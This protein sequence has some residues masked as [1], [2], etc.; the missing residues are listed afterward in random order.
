MERIEEQLGML[1]LTV[2]DKVTGFTGIITSI[3]FDLYGCVQGLVHPGLDKD[4]KPGEQVWFDLNRLMVRRSQPVMPNP[5]LRPAHPTLDS[6]Q[7]KGG[8]ERPRTRAA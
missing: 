4:R 8:Q 2:E 5:H 1:G 6:G 3:T 7:D